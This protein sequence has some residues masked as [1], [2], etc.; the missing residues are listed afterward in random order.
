MRSCTQKARLR[1]AALVA[2]ALVVLACPALWAAK[3][4]FSSGPLAG[5]NGLFDQLPAP[6]AS[7]PA[8]VCVLCTRHPDTL[9]EALRQGPGKGYLAYLEQVTSRVTEASGLPC[10]LIHYVQP[11][12]EALSPRVVR[13]LVIIPMDKSLSVDQ[14]ERLFAFIRGTRIPILGICGGYELVIRAFGGIVN[15][16]RPLRLG[17][18]DP[19]PD[20]PPG[21][22]KEWG[23]TPVRVLQRDPLFDGLGARI[24]VDE[25]H[26]QEVK[27]LPGVFMNLAASDIC[28]LQA[29][30]HRRRLI[31]ATQFHPE[32]YD[33]AHPDGAR[34]LRNFF[35]LAGVLAPAR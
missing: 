32:H 27:H 13:A 26:Q 1:L 2:G 23:F 17:E 30:K 19:N 4:S 21:W 9:R 22:F 28:P 25:R 18:R 24:V 6:T 31:Y 5:V 15:K 20:Y 8:S 35:A 7:G 11:G 16:M 14:V 10:L 34:I 12:L 29:V 3:A 33:A